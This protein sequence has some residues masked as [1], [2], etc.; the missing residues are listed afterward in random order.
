MIKKIIKVIISL[1]VLIGITFF[2]SIKDL[3]AI[4]TTYIPTLWKNITFISGI[5]F[6]FLPF[7]LL[8]LM[9]ILFSTKKWAF[10]VEKLTIGG[11]NVLFDNPEHLFKRQIGT[12]LDTK[13]TLFRVD[14]QYDNFDEILTSYFETYKLLRDEMKILD[15]TKKK[16]RKKTTESITGYNLSNEIIKE[17]NDF[18]TK[19]Q[20]NYRRWYKYMELHEEED[21]YT[22]PIGDLQKKYSNYEELCSD[23]QRVNRFFVE[24]VAPYFNLDIEKWGCDISKSPK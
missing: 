13:R 15:D 17:L 24:R 4:E 23:F 8:I 16:K 18:L 9:I 2:L 11:F 21:Y 5:M 7:L 3:Q 19:H 1:V 14:L 6:A 22:M 12:F 10:R 20:S